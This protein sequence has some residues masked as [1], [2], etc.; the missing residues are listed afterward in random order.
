[1]IVVEMRISYLNSEL[2]LLKKQLLRATHFDS[3]H[4]EKDC[5]VSRGKEML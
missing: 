2:E 1:M 4:L 5:I 3:L